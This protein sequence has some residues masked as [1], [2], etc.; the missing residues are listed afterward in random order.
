MNI[1]VILGGALP[2]SPCHLNFLTKQNSVVDVDG[3][4][5]SYRVLTE[6]FFQ[7][8]I[9]I[10]RQRNHRVIDP[11]TLGNVDGEASLINQSYTVDISTRLRKNCLSKGIIHLSL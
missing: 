1:K 9:S 10:Q 4:Y 8:I 2:L 11:T 6:D 3:G 5:L 7:C